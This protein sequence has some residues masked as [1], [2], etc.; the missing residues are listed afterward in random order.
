[1]SDAALVA[2][3]LVLSCG[4][5][6]SAGY[7]GAARL[8]LTGRLTEIVPIARVLPFADAT[9]AASPLGFVPA[10]TIFHIAPRFPPGL[11]LVMAG[12]IAIGGPGAPFFMPPI[13]GFGAV[14]LTGLMTRARMG[15]TAGGLAAVLLASSPI[16]L[17]MALQPMSDAP[18]MFWVVLAAFL[19]WRPSPLSIGAGLAGGMAVLTRP[20]LALAALTLLVTTRWA[21][22]RQAAAFGITLL[23]FVAALLGM[24]WRMFGD[25]LRSGYGTAGQLFTWA[26]LWPN[27]LDHTTWLLRMHTPL[28]AV[29]CAAGLWFDRSFGWRAGAMFLAIAAPYLAYAPRFEDWEILRFLL[30]GLPFVFAVCAAGVVG[31]A[32]GPSHA[33]RARVA[34]LLVAAAAS[35]VSWTFVSRRHVFDLREQERK[36][37]LVGEWFAKQTPGQAVAIAS[38]HSGSLRYYSGR[39]I[40]RAE[41]IPEHR[42]V[43]TVDALQ[44]AGFA[45]YVALEQDELDDF[46][47]RF[48]P[49]AIPQLTMEPLARIRGVNIFRLTTR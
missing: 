31:L 24:Q 16:F 10:G 42:L 13:L 14:A 44:R 39:P 45:P 23:L 2:G 37:P 17:D 3:H 11:P 8:F 36:Y 28:L 7:L 33:T 25:P 46:V 41:A 43:D 21:T 35:A 32:G 40:V 12:A 34:A 27:A 4:G 19:V 1:V 15:S 5:L 9:A 29:L 26:S 30:P 47:R 18:A 20:P 49:Y 6:D 48:Q 22:R 38:L